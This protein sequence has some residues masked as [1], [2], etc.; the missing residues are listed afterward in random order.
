MSPCT[1]ANNLAC[2]YDSINKKTGVGNADPLTSLTR[3]RPCPCQPLGTV[4]YSSHPLAY[5]LPHHCLCLMPRALKG[6]AYCA[7]KTVAIPTGGWVMKTSL[8]PTAHPIRGIRKLW[9]KR[10][11]REGQAVASRFFVYMPAIISYSRKQL[12][13]C[14]ILARQQQTSGGKSAE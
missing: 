1:S 11:G 3:V 2:H 12:C 14:P 4:S 10:K 13:Y 7:K 9:Q 6:R 8:V 5:I